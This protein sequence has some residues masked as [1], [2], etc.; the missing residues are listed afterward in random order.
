[1][2]QPTSASDTL[3]KSLNATIDKILR[4]RWCLGGPED[5][6]HL[7]CYETI[8]RRHESEFRSVA[9]IDCKLCSQSHRRLA[10]A[11][12]H[13]PSNTIVNSLLQNRIREL[14]LGAGHKRAAVHC[15]KSLESTIEVREV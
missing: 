7:P 2:D 8:C 3:D 12:H 10:N 4:C 1:M 14:D 9:T 15:L 5:P 13:F 11:D 6:V